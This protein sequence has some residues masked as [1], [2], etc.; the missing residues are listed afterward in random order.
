MHNA[1]YL[2]TILLASVVMLLNQSCMKEDL[3]DCPRPFNLTI[4]AWDADMQDITES[5]DLQR[6]VLFIFDEAGKRVD[7]QILSAEHVANRKS[8]Y[9]E[10]FGPKK[11][12]FVG[13]ANP[14]EQMLAETESVNT[15][16]ALEMK[17]ASAANIA[18]TAPDLFSGDLNTEV[19][20]GSV[21]STTDKYLDLYRRTAQV[22]IRVLGYKDWLGNWNPREAIPSHADILLA[23]TPIS[24]SALAELLG[25]EFSYRPLFAELPGGDIFAAPFNIYPTRAE[26]PLD[27]DFFV[28]QDKVL[29]VN[30]DKEGHQ[31]L[32]VVG[33]MLNILIDLRGADVNIAVVVSPWNEVHQFA[34][35]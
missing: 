23:A 27:V 11:L 15:I 32:P 29:S 22:N 20:Y 25:D 31:F 3:S 35:F 4:R 7:R 5:G 2:L 18:A 30:Q 6:V 34:E 1:K 13:W 12:H 24:Y 10:F 26:R 9:V 33:R 14:T 21:T 8:I 19:E 17:L 28:H 16:A